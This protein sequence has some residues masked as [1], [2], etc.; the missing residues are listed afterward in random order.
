MTAARKLTWKVHWRR[1]CL[2]R[3]LGK[4]LVPCPNRVD[5]G[6]QGIWRP[7]V[8]VGDP[9]T[10]QSSGGHHLSDRQTTC[11]VTIILSACTKDSSL[12]APGAAGTKRTRKGKRGG[13]Q[14]SEKSPSISRKYMNVAPRLASPSLHLYVSYT[15]SITSW[16]QPGWEVIC[17]Y[18]S[19]F[20]LWR[21]YSADPWWCYWMIL[22]E[23]GLRLG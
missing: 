22:E 16:P 14:T 12:E 13:I 7:E 23:G 4:V 19:D 8:W 6:G 17:E 10:D 1:G 5:L 11:S 18:T 9:E 3:G 20:C 21:H 15:V 2:W